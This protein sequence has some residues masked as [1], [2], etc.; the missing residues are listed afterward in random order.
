MSVEQENLKSFAKGWF[1]PSCAW[2]IPS[3][4]ETGAKNKDE[5]LALISKAIIGM[6]PNISEY[7]DAIKTFTSSSE[8]VISAQLDAIALKFNYAPENQAPAINN[9]KAE[10]LQEYE[11][12]QSTLANLNKNLGLRASAA[13]H[14]INDEKT[15]V[16][17][18][19]LLSIMNLLDAREA[20]LQAGKIKC[21][22]MKFSMSMSNE[23]KRTEYGAVVNQLE[24]EVSQLCEKVK[25]AIEKIPA[26][27]IGKCSVKEQIAQD[28]KSLPQNS[29]P[30][31]KLIQLFDITTEMYCQANT[32]VAQKISGLVLPVEKEHGVIPLTPSHNT[33]D[34]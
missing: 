19:N 13:I 1:L 30:K 29:D 31:I 24:K 9:R 17:G 3:P 26:G 25:S 5:L 34:F 6:R 20:A 14:L 10:T 21:G 27:I 12:N 2:K 32:T 8:H 15:S 28:F 18:K 16:Y 22:L 7:N 33:N 11:S 23:L 4:E